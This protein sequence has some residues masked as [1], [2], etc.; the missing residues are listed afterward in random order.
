MLENELLTLVTQYGIA[1]L[2]L[3]VFYKLMSNELKKLNESINNLSLKI[4]RLSILIER[5]LSKENEISI[6]LY[7]FVHTCTQDYLLEV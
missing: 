7:T 3:Y 1:G 2:I 6:F 4:E 5:E